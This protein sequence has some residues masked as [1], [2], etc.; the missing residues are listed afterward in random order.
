MRKSRVIPYVLVSERNNKIAVLSIYAL[1]QARCNLGLDA[2]HD[3][4]EK[5][6]IIVREVDIPFSQYSV[7]RNAWAEKQSARC[8]PASKRLD[9]S[10][11]SRLH[12]AAAGELALAFLLQE[13]T[14]EPGAARRVSAGVI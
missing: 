9:S 4:L 8:D 5:R 10:L 11:D 12:S 13:P 1:S 14:S 6:H 7:N 2:V 3:L